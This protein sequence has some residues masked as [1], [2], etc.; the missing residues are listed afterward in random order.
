MSTLSYSYV[1]NGV[2]KLG[3]NG[4]QRKKTMNVDKCAGQAWEKKKQKTSKPQN[5]IN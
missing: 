1:I 2:G 4:I 3:G 5:I